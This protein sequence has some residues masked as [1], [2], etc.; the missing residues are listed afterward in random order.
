MNTKNTLLAALT[1]VVLTAC[2]NEKK[3]GKTATC[4]N[5]TNNSIAVTADEAAAKGFEAIS[6]NGSFDVFYI[7]DGQTSVQL[8]GD[9][10]DIARVK[11][12]CDGKTLNVSTKKDNFFNSSGHDVD[13][14]VTSPKLN[15]IK[16][17]GSGDFKSE[18]NIGTENMDIDIAGSGNVNIKSLESGDCSISIAGSGDVSID[19]M[20]ARNLEARIAG[21]GDIDLQEANIDKAKCK[22]AGSGDIDIDGRIGE[23]EKRITG[24]GTVDINK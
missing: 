9:K 12:E 1:V 6:V 4:N 21:S 20:T 13:I 5:V 22:I 18:S 24:S 17:T 11:I 8:R 3:S 10:D 14:Y 23:C 7:Q 2:A 15:G 16:L 19:H